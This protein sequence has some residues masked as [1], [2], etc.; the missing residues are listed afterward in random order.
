MQNKFDAISRQLDDMFNTFQMQISAMTKQALDRLDQRYAALGIKPQNL[1]S[2]DHLSPIVDK[3][4]STNNHNSQTVA[5]PQS[6]ANL[7]TN[8]QHNIDNTIS[9]NTNL[10]KT[11]CNDGS[12][13]LSPLRSIGPSMMTNVNAAPT[14]LSSSKFPN[15][16]DGNSVQYC[17]NLV[18]LD[19]DFSS[20]GYDHYVTLCNYCFCLFQMVCP[21]MISQPVICH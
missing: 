20:F 18:Y 10:L 12:N 13:Y 8:E 11:N 16:Y 21:G 1:N 6:N 17:Y 4:V 3:N 15:Q 9:S 14:Q 7:V 5:T 19:L 2:V